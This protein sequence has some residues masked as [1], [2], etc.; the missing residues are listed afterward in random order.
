MY[1]GRITEIGTVIETSPSLVIHARK[2]A[3]EL[4]PGGS[5]DVNG[6]CSWRRAAG[7]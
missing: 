2:T 6:T 3:A 4:S 5:V 7:C 1:S